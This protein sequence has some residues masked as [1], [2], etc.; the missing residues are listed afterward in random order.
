MFI[1]CAESRAASALLRWSLMLESKDNEAY[2]KKCDC[3]FETMESFLWA[4]VD[5]EVKARR[6]GK[7]HI[8]S[9]PRTPI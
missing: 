5:C 2:N 1:R 3:D 9:R 4:G 8:R 6:T 7:G